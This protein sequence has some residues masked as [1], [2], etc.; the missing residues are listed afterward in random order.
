MENIALNEH[1]KKVLRYN[2]SIAKGTLHV[3]VS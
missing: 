1:L 3:G 2:N